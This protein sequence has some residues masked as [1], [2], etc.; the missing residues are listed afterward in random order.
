MRRRAALGAGLA[1]LA[2]VA[3]LPGVPT[4]VVVNGALAAELTI[5]TVSLV[6]L[7]G[8]VG[9]ISLGQGAFV[10]I[11]AF[12]TGL[13]ARRAGLGFPLTL[14]VA[15]AAAGVVAA[16]L[17]AV[18]LRIRGLY[19]AVATLIVAWACDAYLFSASWFVGSGGA[20]TIPNR[21]I[22]RPGTLTA[23]DLSDPRTFL[24]VALAAASATVL[25]AA[26]LR[27]SKTGRAF[28]AV[29]GSEVAAASLGVDVTRTKLVAFALSGTLA[30]A[31][32]NL[33]MTDLR[34][35][36]PTEFQFTVS[37]FYLSIAVVGG[38][39]SLG[40]AVAS[41]VL[42]AG[43]NELFLRVPPL[44]G[45]LDIVS[46]ALLLLVLAA[47][48]GGLGALGA[49]AWRRLAPERPAGP[50]TAPD[51]APARAARVGSAPLPHPDRL[52]HLD[53]R[54]CTDGVAGER[55]AVLE[56]EGITVRFAGLTALEGACLT[57][58]Q[59]EVVGLIGPNGAGKTTLFNAVA[60]L[61]EPAAGRVRLFGRDVTRLP[62]HERAR[63]GVARTFQ[64]LQLFPELSVFENLLVATHAHDPTGLLDHL[65]VTERS[66]RAERAARARVREV[67][68]LVGIAE[69]LE[70]PVAGLPFGV[71][72]RVEIARALV[73]GGR[74]LMLDEPASGLGDAETDALAALLLEVRT[75]LGASILVIEHDVRMVLGCS[76]RVTV[77]DQ[78]RVL[79]E[80]TPAEIRRH[81][82]V[83]RAYLG[84]PAE[85]AAAVPS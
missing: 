12:T 37:L 46:V 56:A 45:W 82:A 10:G 26:N 69:L 74:L 61:V 54:P 17:G 81:S 49:A 48:P 22:G 67:A 41:S 28:F 33:V 80:G 3:W 71:L 20:S 7:T 27:D 83:V 68:E 73:S 5:V 52:P 63:L 50:A 30:G 75:Q 4:S 65:V 24:L 85:P 15:A 47:Y 32:G 36:T 35:V 55:P 78:G 76:D 13:L 6:I 38:I 77:L 40:G 21:P 18:A 39:R 53:G 64:I 25:A 72:R 16:L 19:L 31:A 59:G 34:T 23:F 60:G 8:W 11:G 2:G 66:L 84:G 57:V 43:L 9:Q 44:N 79:A 1:L 62:V 58:R 29:R 51:G 14:P 42:F 70:R